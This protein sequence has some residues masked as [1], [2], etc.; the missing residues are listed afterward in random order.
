VFQVGPQ[1][2][3][4]VHWDHVLIAEVFHQMLLTR[5]HSISL[6][7]TQILYPHLRHSLP[8]TTT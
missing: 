7:S 6:H 5:S 2:D 4:S 1:C 8:T 3:Y